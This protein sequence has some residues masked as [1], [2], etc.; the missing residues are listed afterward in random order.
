MVKEDWQ[1]E[2]VTMLVLTTLIKVRQ[3]CDQN[4][5]LYRA[6]QVISKREEP[7]WG[8]KEL[9][10]KKE[11]GGGKEADQSVFLSWLRALGHLRG[12]DCK[13]ELLFPPMEQQM[14]MMQ[15]MMR[16]ET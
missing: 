1:R 11:Q 6:K 15:M 9:M 4:C 5:V 7:K 16:V 10:K 2:E 12:K 13:L 14:M 3:E 8:Q